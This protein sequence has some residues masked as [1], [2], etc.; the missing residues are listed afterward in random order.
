[1]AASDYNKAEVTAFGAAI[2]DLV[3]AARDGVSTDDLGALI[4]AVTA[5]AA[6]VNEMK[7]VPAAAGLHAL[8]AASDRVGDMFLADAIAAEG[9]A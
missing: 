8:G 7:D 2:G 3:N 4:D 6:T 1:M 5:G 9:I